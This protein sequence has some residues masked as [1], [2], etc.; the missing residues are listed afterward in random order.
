MATTDLRAGVAE[1]AGWCLNHVLEAVD[2]LLFVERL[3]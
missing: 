1:G 3:E 2:T